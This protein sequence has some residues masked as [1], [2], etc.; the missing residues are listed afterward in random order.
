MTHLEKMAGAISAVVAVLTI[1]GIGLGLIIRITKR[2]TQIEMRLAALVDRVTEA[3]T[4]V[5]DDNHR[6]ER[7]VDRNEDRINRHEEWH[8]VSTEHGQRS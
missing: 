2:W 8:A 4:G 7:R 6:L 3:I 5:K 1:L